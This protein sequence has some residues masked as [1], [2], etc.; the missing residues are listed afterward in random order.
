MTPLLGFSPDMESPTPG[1]IVDCSQFIPYETGM[2]AAP[3]LETISG[4]PALA[5]PCLG[6]VVATRLDGTR[7]VFAGT[8]D[9]LY[10]LLAGVW[11]DVSR[12]SP[13][14][15]GPDTRWSF[16]QFGNTT[17]AANRSNVIQSSTSGD[18]ADIAGAPS[19]EVVFSVGS[20]VMALNVNDGAEK[21]NGWHCCAAFDASDW[22]ESTVTQSAS[23]QLVSS[24]GQLTAGLRLGEYAIAYK[25]RSIY[26]GQYV[27]PPAVWDWTLVAGGE[28]GCVGKDAV[29][30]IDGSHFFVGPDNLWLFNGTRPQPFGDKQLRQWFFNN[31]DGT[32]LYK[33]QCIYDRQQNRLWIF[34]PS[35]GSDVL[36]S[37]LVYHL[38]NGQWGRAD[39]SI[40]AL[41]NYIQ[42]GFTYDD[43][44]TVGAT[45]DDLPDIPYDSQYWLAGGAAL[46]AFNTS[47]QLQTFT[48]IP[49]TSSFTTGDAGDDDGVTLL[50]RVRL[51]FANGQNPATA[52]IQTFHKMSSGESPALGVTGAI[53]DGKFD[54]LRAAR[55]H[56]CTI[57]FTGR[58]R[59]TGIMPELGQAGKR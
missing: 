22:T 24:P 33:T 51:R 36:D 3:S 9:A 2:E 11:T 8:D 46:S 32:N 15:G 27:G 56:R 37:A 48:G 49:G 44:D 14:T 6:A 30:D 7:R 52:N 39:R 12:A 31:A 35:A 45:Y 1:V 42:P 20:F 16:A 50:K 5:D 54:V 59:V 4:V 38:K 10:E 55:W 29:C 28:A 40:Q 21:E 25:A 47:N 57:T 43:W 41:V 34:Y 13:Y 23:G 18:F 26:L 19:A 58:V 53:N 17:I